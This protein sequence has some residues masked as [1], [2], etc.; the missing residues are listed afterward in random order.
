MATAPPLR[1]SA[2]YRDGENVPLNLQEAFKW[3]LK[4]AELGNAGAEG[5]VGLAYAKGSGVA[6]D[7]EQAVRWLRLSAA[8]KDAAGLCNLGYLYDMGWGVPHDDHEAFRLALESANL[9][10]GQAKFNLGVYYRDGK[11]TKADPLTSY[12]W[13]S[14]ATREH[15][16]QAQD[17]ADKM[18]KLLTPAQIA[19]AERRLAQ[20]KPAPA[21]EYELR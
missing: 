13:F 5:A 16:P 18:R 21:P 7:Y 19:E 17:R 3:F 6:P 12:F 11:G 1:T 14:I 9:G 20:W 8:K 2:S 4:G 15:F 10:V